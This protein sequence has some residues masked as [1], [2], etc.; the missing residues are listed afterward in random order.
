V[1]VLV[2]I[3]P[4]MASP[5]RA[6]R[7]PPATAS[8]NLGQPQ[9]LFG[10][11]VQA[12]VSPRRRPMDIETPPTSDAPRFSSPNSSSPTAASPSAREVDGN[13]EH[14][15]TRDASQPNDPMADLRRNVTALLTLV[16]GGEPAAKTLAAPH[17]PPASVAGGA[18]LPSSIGA[19]AWRGTAAASG[20]R[21]GR[22]PRSPGSHHC[23]AAGSATRSPALRPA[24][25]AR[26][27][28]HLLQLA[29]SAE[30]W[31]AEQPSP[32]A[33]T[34]R[35]SP[36]V[37][38]SQRP[39][40]EAAN[41]PEVVSTQPTAAAAAVAAAVVATPQARPKA[42]GVADS[43]IAR[44]A[45]DLAHAALRAGDFKHAAAV[46]SEFSHTEVLRPQL[47]ADMDSSVTRTAT[48][49][50]DD[51]QE[52]QQQQQESEPQPSNRPSRRRLRTVYTT[53]AASDSSQQQA[54]DAGY[55]IPLVE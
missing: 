40:G 48:R 6:A 39:A 54:E 37:W 26:A 16:H 28:S 5:R 2:V 45:N 36:R 10:A 33:E 42:D 12:A 19:A 24:S 8:R 13:G 34:A 30:D 46:I 14:R 9:P 51:Q 3:A 11:S 22:S 49:S 31:L 7:S 41:Q 32:L 50:S 18:A 29:R 55:R 1:D 23:T 43:G 17:Q 20:D 15:D 27:D 4:Q 25:P 44:R 35:G 38:S 21:A 47:A 52:E 53:V